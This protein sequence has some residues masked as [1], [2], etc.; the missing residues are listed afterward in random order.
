MP[1]IT[2][3]LTAEEVAE[4]KALGIRFRC[5]SKELLQQFA[6]DL[7]GS[8]RTRGS[9]ERVHAMDYATRTFFDH[10]AD[11][12]TPEEKLSDAQVEKMEAY[13]SEAYR[14]RQAQQEQW[15]AEHAAR[16]AASP[17]SAPQP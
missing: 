6:S 5:K 17:L 11:Y 14:H 3:D 7:T 1:K 12:A 16:V 4:L 10:M 9:D 2:L 13:H 15:R 8:L